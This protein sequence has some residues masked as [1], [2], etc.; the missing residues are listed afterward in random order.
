MI[1]DLGEAGED[2]ADD[3]DEIKAFGIDQILTEI[4]RIKEYGKV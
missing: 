1:D 4:R 3:D 2:E